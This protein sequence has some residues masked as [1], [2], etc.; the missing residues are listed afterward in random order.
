M[1]LFGNPVTAQRFTLRSLVNKLENGILTLSGPALALSGILAGIDLLTGGSLFKDIGWFSVTWAICLLL[2][3]DFQVLM[4]GTRAKRIY[5]GNGTKGQKILEM[6]VLIAIAAGI[7]WVSI[8]MQSVV[9]RS[10]STSTFIDQQGQ[11][12]IRTL[13][14]EEA[15]R[16]M[17]INSSALI[18]ERSA[19]V[20]VLIFVSGWLRDEDHQHQEQQLSQGQPTP[21]PL[22][23]SQ[24]A[25]AMGPFLQP[26]ISAIRTT[27]VEELRGTIAAPATLPM[28]ETGTAR[29]DRPQQ[30][31]SETEA[32]ETTEQDS[33][34]NRRGATEGLLQQQGDRTARQENACRVRDYQAEHPNATRQDI[35]TALE[36]SER[37]VSRYWTPPSETESQSQP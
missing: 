35:A 12:H 37:T 13:T 28:I 22:D 21:V 15:T 36:I 33:Q 5:R 31:D 16:D 25:Q 4:L 9:A 2:A 34:D 26:H 11:Q 10:Q 7:S 3:L 20:L 6:V 19:L 32:T 30:R 29:Q 27:I 1:T 18:W 24:L 8:Q 17:G 23:Y 14:V